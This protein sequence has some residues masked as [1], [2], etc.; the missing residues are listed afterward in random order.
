LSGIGP[1]ETLK[2]SV[3]YAMGYPKE[4]AVAGLP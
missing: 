4:G 2:F 3:T 1:N